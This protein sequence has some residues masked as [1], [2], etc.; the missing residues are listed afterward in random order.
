MT[1]VRWN[2][3][4]ELDRIQREMNRIFANPNF[5]DLAPAREE[6][7]ARG[8]IPA[9]DISEDVEK[10]QLAVEL[11][12]L[13]RKDIEVSIED[14]RLTISGERRFEAKTDEKNFTRVERSYGTFSRSFSLPN[15]VDVDRVE[16]RM[17]KGV[18][19]VSLF[20]RE[21]AKPKQIAVQVA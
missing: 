21:E 9:V 7:M 4:S 14:G 13:D 1:L 16:A 11:P 3:F 17:D 12:G 19:I 20:K 2:P 18:L 5:G 15:T 6:T 10:I 8:F